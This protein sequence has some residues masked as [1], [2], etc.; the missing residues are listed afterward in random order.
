[1]QDAERELASTQ[2]PAASKLRDA[3]GEM[4]QNDLTTRVQRSADWLRRGIDPTSN[5]MEAGIGSDLQRLSQQMHGAQQAL[6]SGDSQDS[7]TASNQSG[8]E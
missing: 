5:S 8:I 3:L 7:Q 4:E 6:G 1:M 2:R